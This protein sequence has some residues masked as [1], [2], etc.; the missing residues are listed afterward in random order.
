MRGISETLIAWAAVNGPQVTSLPPL[1]AANSVGSSK[2]DLAAFSARQKS[3]HEN[4]GS[5]ASFRQSGYE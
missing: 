1:H 4:Q 2:P 5:L 3:S